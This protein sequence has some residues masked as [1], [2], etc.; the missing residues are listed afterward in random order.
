M[1]FSFILRMNV[2]LSIQRELCKIKTST[3]CT[4]GNGSKL[5]RLI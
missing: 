2:P 4:V 1:T 3:R 5:I